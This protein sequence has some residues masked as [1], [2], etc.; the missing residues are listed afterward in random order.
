M[1]GSNSNSYGSAPRLSVRAMWPPSL[2]VPRQLRAGGFCAA[3]V[4]ILNGIQDSLRGKAVS[5][6]IP[7][8]SPITAAASARLPSVIERCWHAATTAPMPAPGSTASMRTPSRSA[9]EQLEEQARADPGTL[10]RLPLYGVPFA[11]KDNIDVAGLPTTAACPAFSYVPQRSAT[12]VERLRG[13]RR[14]P[15]GQDQPRPV[16]HRARRHAL[17]L[18]RRVERL[19]PRIHLGWLQLRL[20][21]GR[22]ARAGRASRSGPTPPARAACRPG[23]TTWSD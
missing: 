8:F 1:V 23:S 16:R 7:R 6:T 18:R 22:R 15:G 3:S 19:S 2:A 17:A 13:R 4:C 11:V 14:D 10:D 21:G 5:M 9:P 12:V 20:S